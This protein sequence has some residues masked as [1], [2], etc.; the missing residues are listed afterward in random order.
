MPQAAISKFESCRGRARPYRRNFAFLEHAVAIPNPLV[1]MRN[2]HARF[3]R[4][5]PPKLPRCLHAAQRG[6]QLAPP[7]SKRAPDT[8]RRPL[9]PHRFPVGSHPRF[10]GNRRKWGVFETPEF[11]VRMGQYWCSLEHGVDSATEEG[12]RCR[13]NNNDCPGEFRALFCSTAPPPGSISPSPTR[14][15]T[16]CLLFSFPVSCARIK[17]LP[18]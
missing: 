10:S 14:L 7:K 18:A 5:P 12:I 1:S 11:R 2:Y 3:P 16:L 6:Q 17:L 15:L 13:G 9:H 4:P 8:E